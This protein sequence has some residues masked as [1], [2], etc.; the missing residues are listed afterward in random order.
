M[1]RFFAFG[2]SF[3]S[4]SWPTWADIIAKENAYYE[5][6]GR[7]GSGNF[8]IF[9]SLNECILRNKITKDDLVIIMWSS[10][11]REDRYVNRQ[12]I[13]QGNI[14]N[15]SLY[16]NNFTK[17][18]C[19]DRGYLLRDL[20]IISATKKILD[21]IGLEYYF[22]SMMP[23]GLDELGDNNQHQENIDLLEFYNDVLK[24]IRPS[25]YEKIF[26]NNWFQ[27]DRKDIHPDSLE[28]LE[29]LDQVLPEISIQEQTRKW[30]HEIDTLVKRNESIN[31]IWLRQ[32][33]ERF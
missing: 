20:N 13:G 15:Q 32:F 22:L 8:Y 19:D 7:A 23:V 30:V 6:W 26:N 21:S 27:E 25:I 9:N 2:C 12:W 16:D 3:T 24:T 10:I 4:Y 28:F 18:F 11:S 29:Y 31:K 1:K 33:P 17:E 14:Y 5:N